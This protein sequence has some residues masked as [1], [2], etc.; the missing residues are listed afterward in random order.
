MER[1][2]ITS[3]PEMPNIEASI[4][5]ARYAI[6]KSLVKDKKVLDIACGEGYGSY[7]LKRAGAKEVVGVDVSTAAIN[8]ARQSLDSE[9][10]QFVLSDAI[11][12]HQHYPD[13]YFDV[14]VSCETIEHVENPDAYLQSLKKL[15]KKNA[16]F[17]ITCPN[18]YWYYPEIH[19]SNPYH[20]RKYRFK[21]FQQLATSVLGENVT[22]SIGT[23]VFGFGSTPL[24]IRQGYLQIPD[25]WMSFR[26][27]DG[28]YLVNGDEEQKF[29][30]SN[31]SY[32]IGVWNAVEIPVGMA[33]FPVS[34]NCYSR[35]VPA[36]NGGLPQRINISLIGSTEEVNV[37][38]PDL[39][40]ARLHF[41]AAMSENEIL[42]ESLQKYKEDL[43][44][45]QAELDVCRLARDK[46]RVAHD[47]YVWLR[48]F[49]PQPIRALTVK[50][51]LM[52]RR[53]M[54]K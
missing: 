13:E 54:H 26:E 35:M 24:N 7:L 23:A 19:Q 18:D 50:F 11:G 33:V 12:M 45:V 15:A 34:M 25:S 4:H 32:F 49:V 42:K 20:L 5:F 31:C 10:I 40:S 38:T 51:V 37:S 2:D 41:Q 22:W 36:M 52:I 14:V 28:A 27:I 8:R 43:H 9:G 17:I 16:L 3:V 53:E 47:R 46:M 48:S 1:L 29:S 6:A 21:E 39:Q 30:D 44:T